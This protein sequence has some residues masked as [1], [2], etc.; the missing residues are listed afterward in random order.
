MLV[1]LLVVV[2]LLR[3]PAAAA[4]AS[5]LGLGPAPRPPPPLLLLL[6]PTAALLLLAAAAWGVCSDAKADAD[7]ASRRSDAPIDR[8]L[9]PAYL[10]RCR[11]M[12]FRWLPPCW[13]VGVVCE[14]GAAGVNLAG[15]A[16]IPS[17]SN[18]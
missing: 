11:C 1:V 8:R 3:A 2:L 10:I 7:K 9:S 6:L 12:A 15:H 4:A 5:V 18:G 14:G 17:V 16:I 13:V